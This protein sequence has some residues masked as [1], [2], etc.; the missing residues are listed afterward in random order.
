MERNYTEDQPPID[1]SPLLRKVMGAIGITA[2]TLPLAAHIGFNSTEVEKTLPI[3][4]ERNF[5][6]SPSFED[7]LIADLGPSGKI[8]IE[9]TSPI[10]VT[11]DVGGIPISQTADSITPQSKQNIA[12]EVVNSLFTLNEESINYMNQSI[13]R[14]LLTDFFKKT[15]LTEAILLAGIFGARRRFSTK[16]IATGLIATT[17]LLG[18]ITADNY[19]NVDNSNDYV[20]FNTSLGPLRIY[21]KLTADLLLTKLPSLNEMYTSQTVANEVFVATVSAQLDDTLN[22]IREMQPEGTTLV[23]I[24]SDIHTTATMLD[25]L[26]YAR[27]QIEPSLVLNAGDLTNYDSEFELFAAKKLDPDV[28]A[29]GN[30]DGSAIREALQK[31][32]A[33]LSEEP[34][35]IEIPLADGMSSL[36]ILT[37]EDP[38]YTAAGTKGTIERTPGA[39]DTMRTQLLEIASDNDIDIVLLHEPSDVQFLIDNGITFNLAI[40]GHTH[41]AG[42][43]ELSDGRTWLQVGTTG[44]IASRTV[45]SL[46]SPLTTP[47]K[48][49]TYSYVALD[50]ETGKLRALYTLTVNPGGEVRLDTKSYDD[51]P[52]IPKRTPPTL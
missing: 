6:F 30:H 40:S 36:T 31:A 1:K 16:E 7:G 4:G 37:A 15:A 33:L 13:E 46:F 34:A 11:I 27:S 47:S 12:I 38:R 25:I 35:L 52:N 22:D 26:T 21:D 45:A 44:G 17:A 43:V 41:K 5:V 28:I 18:G 32:G 49:A 51:P 20:T 50:E 8:G 2:A 14:E 42:I 19:S 9:T 29:L 10:G 23:E 3:A 39:I 48:D 24:S